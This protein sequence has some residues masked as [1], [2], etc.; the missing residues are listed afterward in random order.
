MARRKY[1]PDF[2]VAIF[3]HHYLYD[4][5]SFNIWNLHLKV[6]SYS[7]LCYAYILMYLCK[8]IFAQITRS[9][10]KKFKMYVI[11]TLRN[12]QSF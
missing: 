10:I 2:R 6:Q 7:K 9:R 12:G 8:Y 11:F 1:L 3:E 4:L 5:L